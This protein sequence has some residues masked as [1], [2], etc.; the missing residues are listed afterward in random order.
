M[1]SETNIDGLL[2]VNKPRGIS[3]RRAVDRVNRCFG[4]IKS[5]H[6][7]TLDPLASGL[8]IVGLGRATRTL[9]HLS[10]QPKT[11]RAHVRLG[12]RTATGDLEGEVVETKDFILPDKPALT[13]CCNSLCGETVQV[14]PKYSAL[15]HC[16][17]RFYELAR[18]GE[19]VPRRERRVHIYRM[20]AGEVDD[21]GFW[22]DVE[23]SSGTYIRA[24]AE[25]VGRR[26]GTV[27]CLQS[28]RR[29][30][31]GVFTLRQS[32]PLALFDECSMQPILESLLPP[33]RAFYDLPAVVL[34]PARAR[35]FCCGQAV[36]TTELQPA[37]CR[38]YDE[39]RR[40]LGVATGD[41][42][43]LKPLKVLA[44]AFYFADAS[45]VEAEPA[46]DAP[47]V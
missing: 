5:G 12:V 10:S 29:T 34:D 32:L 11:Y 1:S 37:K 43:M 21:S 30:A 20:E 23:C 47:A 3:S 13:A 39:S 22:F 8:L 18:N 17:K 31:I 26:L 35:A 42:R 28:L 41:G 40:F 25:D 24:L 27:A 4:K 33:D 45:P 2:L 38:V 14:A 9:D 19:P 16:G 36:S 46:Q 7:G 44:P 6:C 15:K